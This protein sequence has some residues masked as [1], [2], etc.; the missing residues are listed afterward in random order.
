M[1]VGTTDYESKVACQ[2]WTGRIRR[3][4][5]QAEDRR[6]NARTRPVTAGAPEPIA[7]LGVALR[8]VPPP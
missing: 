2:G 6:D 3:A 7:A 1:F 4:P 8:P 5:G